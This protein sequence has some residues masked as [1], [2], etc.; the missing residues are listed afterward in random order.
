ARSGNGLVGS[1][2]AYFAALLAKETAIVFP[3]VI[4]AVSL[5]ASACQSIS[6]DQL[7]SYVPCYA[8]WRR[9]LRHTLPFVAATGLYLLMRLNALGVAVSAKTQQLPRMSV[10]LSWPAILWFYARVLFWPWRPYSFADP[11]VIDT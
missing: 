9:S 1:V 10:I 3:V 4:F 6:Q 7:T 11:I 8:T 5:S 2:A